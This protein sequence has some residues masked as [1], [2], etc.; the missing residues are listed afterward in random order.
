M[1]RM[2]SI[3]D[4][5]KGISN[6]QGQGIQIEVSVKP[7]ESAGKDH[8]QLPLQADQY[9]GSIEEHHWVRG[10]ALSTYK[11]V[12]GAV[13]A[14]TM[15]FSS[16]F[17]LA[18]GFGT[19]GAVIGGVLGTMVAGPI[20][21]I[22]GKVAGSL[23]GA[24]A[25][26]KLQ[27]KTGIGRKIAGRI[28][29]AMGE[30]LGVVA[31]AL[32]I[33]LRSDHIEETKNYSHETMKSHLGTTK[34]TSHPHI[35]KQDA[36]KFIAQLKPGDIVLTNDEAC[37][38]FTLLIVAAGGK[39]D[40]NH[41]IL[42]TGDGKTIESRTVTHGVAEG[43]LRDVLL[44]KHHAVAVR[45]RF[46]P[47]SQADDTVKAG[48]SMIGTKYDFLF[49]MGDDSMYCSEVVYKAVREG[50]PQIDFKKR[51]LITKEVILPGDLLRTNKADVIAEVGKD[52]PLF[53]AYMAKFV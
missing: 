2:V 52:T 13:G 29:G 30:M 37:T 28:G 45:P 21:G 25:G 4:M 43:D 34:Y 49:G 40:F 50:A 36:E 3:M 5:A 31:K 10:S 6:I 27:A 41:A 18:G 16:H 33:P 47:A 35:N 11:K 51:P 12:G 24:Y 20:G 15:A 22:V 44:H 23:V 7:K 1:V 19:A 53:N 17:A 39:G 48:K 32:K 26:V 38:I 8:G 14:A 42:H 46:E 9:K